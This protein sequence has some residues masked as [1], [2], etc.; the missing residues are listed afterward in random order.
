MLTIK[1]PN[2]VW[3]A[4]AKELS[5]S[6][7]LSLRVVS[8]TSR[9]AVDEFIISP[10]TFKT[11][12]TQTKSARYLIRTINVP[13]TLQLE[14]PEGVYDEYIQPEYPSPS[15]WK[16]SVMT[17][18]SYLSTPVDLRSVFHCLDA[19][20]FSDPTNEQI[21]D[22]ECAREETGCADSSPKVCI[23]N[24]CGCLSAFFPGILDVHYQ[25]FCRGDPTF[26]EVKAKKKGRPA[27]RTF[28]NQCT[29]RI[30]INH[31]SLSSRSQR[32]G[33]QWNIINLKMFQN[34]K[35][36][37]TGCKS[38]E[39]ARSSVQ[40]LIQ[41]IMEKAPAMRYKLDCMTQIRCFGIDND[42]S[43]DIL[44]EIKQ[45][46]T[47]T[48]SLAFQCNHRDVWYNILLYVHNESLFACRA[49]CKL[50]NSL[51]E[52]DAFWI[53]KCAREIRCTCVFDTNKGWYITEKYNGRFNRMEPVRKP[54]YFT[55]PRLLYSKHRSLRR[56]R[57]FLVA[58]EYEKLF[59]AGEQIAMINSDFK[60]NFELNLHSLYKILRRDYKLQADY[61]PDGYVAINVKY[62]S[63]IMP[64]PIN[65]DLQSFDLCDNKQTVISFFI[66]RT[67]SVIINSA[68]TIEQQDEA[69]DFLNAIFKKHYKRIWLAPNQINV[70]NE[71]FN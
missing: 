37:M 35:I 15:E 8:K 18:V 17:V 67:G 3:R 12:V 46:R 50:L 62:I 2:V 5:Q 29:M 13:T 69:Y 59:I 49:V 1:Q 55:H 54:E 33:Q 56:F 28:N 42:G 60:T 16:I 11:F 32:N 23:A 45:S 71:T 19:V 25:D 24:E 66:F 61:S 27:T 48:A 6:D 57:P 39:Q 44:R 7:L 51:V 41:K 47:Q 43:R 34:G 63:P 65:I 68:R 38:V 20:D 22:F 53:E 30:C 14:L 31:H 58:E 4:L 26:A 64:D 21:I 70:K 10:K 52:S 9:I 36:Q 40:F